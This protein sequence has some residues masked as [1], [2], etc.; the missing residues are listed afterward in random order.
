MLFGRRSIKC[1]TFGFGQQLN[2]RF[3]TIDG[4]PSCDTV[5]ER[6]C[7]LKH[8]VQGGGSTPRVHYETQLSSLE[9]IVLNLSLQAYL[10]KI[11]NNHDDSCVPGALR[12][13]ENTLYYF[14]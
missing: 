1:T 6:F 9:L 13:G 8:L 14:G 7:L 10:P 4:W 5:D 3:D 12:Y 11:I 2:G